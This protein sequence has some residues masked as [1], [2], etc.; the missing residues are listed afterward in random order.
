MKRLILEIS[1]KAFRDIS[2]GGIETVAQ[3]I[4]RQ[5]SALIGHADCVSFLMWTADGSEILDYRSELT[6]EIEWARWIGIANKPPHS[7]GGRTLHDIR[8]AYCDNPPIVTYERLR[9]VV[10]ILKRVVSG[11]TGK[12]V[13]VGTTFDPGPEFAESSFKY[14]R[15]REI[16]AGN[17]MGQGQWVNCGAR[18]K[19][20]VRQYAAYP[21]GIP[22]DTSLGTFLGAQSKHF[23]ADMGFDYLWLS[24]GFAFSLSAWS[25]TGEVFD[26]TR[27]DTE[28]APVV[29]KKI[30]DFWQDF[31]HECPDVPLETRGSNLSTGMD[32]SSDASPMRD[33]YRGGFNLIA[34][35]NSPWAA[36]DGDYGLEITGWLSHIAELPE[37]GTY[38]FRYY[39]HDPW[40]LNSPWLDRYGR[41][42]HDIYLPLSCSR[43]DA[44]GGIQ[45]PDSVSLL[46]IDDSYGRMPDQ[47]PLEVTPHIVQ[48]LSAAP[49]APGAVTW[50][51]PFDEYHDWTFATPS[52]AS[53]VFFGDW[54]MR[55]AVNQGFPL[56][57]VVST[58]NFLAAFEKNPHL[59]AGTIL[60]CPVP[61]AKSI[62]TDAIISIADRGGKV[63]LYGPTR[64]ASM[65]LRERMGVSIATPVEGEMAFSTTLTPDIVED[66]AYADRIRVPA[67]L[68]GG[69]L[70][71]VSHGGGAI[72]MAEAGVGAN[73]RVFS[74]ISSTKSGGAIGW[75]RGAFCET[76][77]GGQL[78]VG[79]DPRD[80][81]QA[82]RLMRWML[83]E[84]GT[85]L[86]LRKRDVS[87]GDPVI[88]ASRSRNAYYFSGFSRSTTARLI[89]R[90]PQGVPIPVGCD[91]AIANGLGEISL[92]RAWQRECRVFVDQIESSEVTC[93]EQYSGEIGVTRRL[94]VQGLRNATV[95]FY[96]DPAFVDAGVRF[97]ER[98]G[99]LG[100]GSSIPAHSIKPGVLQAVEVNGDLLISW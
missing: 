86:R 99:Y 27:F 89:W 91:V 77:N 82:A 46:T 49:D 13:T 6:D 95:S 5:W 56:N 30:L 29:N 26:G 78:P 60:T 39:I 71:E 51:Y 25:V 40:W 8:T 79:D 68:S 4:A 63:L 58:S 2:D 74:S 43:I 37:T 88:V 33:I 53:E 21:N 70:E 22:D 55:A 44:N 66:G 35:P 3:T 97:Q 23:L 69:G 98:I 20:D 65:A 62:L 31:R 50:I 75:I 94:L 48:A 80:F 12:A 76:L 52:R 47:V 64:H 19:G 45:T 73:S 93:R 1:L 41:E 24:N 85:V 16:A 57:T 87:T 36:L 42:P 72:T 84:F 100:L 28:T 83:A 61:D 59:F 17:T 14:V 15:H 34:P 67:L 32:L 92:S 11:L 7:S 96:A 10:T 9:A 90:F 54:F 81:F 38:P 18:L